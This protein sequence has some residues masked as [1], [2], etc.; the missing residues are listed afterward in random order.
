M[1]VIN[2]NDYVKFAV[3]SK[4]LDAF[5]IKINNMNAFSMEGVE[6]GC[7]PSKEK[8]ERFFSKCISSKTTPPGLIGFL[9]QIQ[10]GTESDIHHLFIYRCLTILDPGNDIVSLTYKLDNVL[11]LN[12]GLQFKTLQIFEDNTITVEI[13]TKHSDP[14]PW[15][16]QV[17]VKDDKVAFADMTTVSSSANRSDRSKTA[18]SID[19]A[20]MELGH[21]KEEE[22]RQLYDRIEILLAKRAVQRSFD[23]LGGSVIINGVEQSIDGVLDAFKEI[24]ERVDIT[25]NKES[26]NRDI[27]R[28]SDAVDAMIKVFRK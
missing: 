7:I 10:L 1:P 12:K 14:N 27:D 26:A 11:Q 5:R 20:L 28:I 16:I 2:L 3:I 24:V 23:T 9:C 18:F 17:Y 22:L 25:L 4:Q 15:V 8:I 19:E 21:Y 13:V 6:K